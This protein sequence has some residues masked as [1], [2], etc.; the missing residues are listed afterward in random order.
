[1]SK[2]K[3]V[4]SLIDK[5]AGRVDDFTLD[6]QEKAELLQEINKAQLEVN[7]IEA[8]QTGLLVRWRP[9]LGWVLSFAFGYHYLIQPFLIFIFA[10]NGNTIDLPTFD[11]NTMT[12]VLFGMLGMAGMRSFEK[13]KGRA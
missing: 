7:K 13:V 8:G 3:I 1:M 10:A 2:L 4:G 9:F 12:T 5:V 11:M 6:K